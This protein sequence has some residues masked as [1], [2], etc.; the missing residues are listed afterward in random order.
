MST[1]EEKLYD[2]IKKLDIKSHMSE[3]AKWSTKSPEGE[4]V[5][6]LSFER[7][8]KVCCNYLLFQ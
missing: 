8:D 6:R 2:L 1:D 7:H 4:P 5:K 3:D